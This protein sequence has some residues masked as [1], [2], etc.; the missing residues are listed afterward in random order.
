MQEI[1]WV[2]Y[3]GALQDACETAGQLVSEQGRCVFLVR[4]FSSIAPVKRALAASHCGF[5]VQVA[6]L[7]S[8]VEDLWQ[9]HGTGAPFVSALQQRFDAAEAAVK[10]HESDA[11]ARTATGAVG[12]A[13]AMGAGAAGATDAAAAAQGQAFT[14][15]EGMVRVIVRLLRECAPFFTEEAFEHAIEQAF[16]QGAAA[17]PTLSAA[18]KEIVV[19]VRCCLA[20]PGRMC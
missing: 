5:G 12:V 6:T 7:A 9:L 1:A 18:E 15:A 4:D 10:G 16:S 19:L 20:Y 17:L 2:S 14:P 8:W 11:D 3:D 13:D